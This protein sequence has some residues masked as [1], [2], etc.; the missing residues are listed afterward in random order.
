MIEA[1]F[2]NVV[3]Q[4]RRQ[5]ADSVSFVKNDLDYF[6]QYKIDILARACT[7]AG[8]NPSNILDF[9][10]GIGNS[11]PPLRSA[12]PDA[13]INCLDVSA[14]S[15]K[16]CAQQEVSN[17]SVHIYDG[18]S[19]PFVD[20]SIDLAFT[21][22]VFHHIP[23]ED[24]ILL[25][26]EIRRSLRPGGRFMLFEHNPYNPLTQWAV[27]RCPFD[28]HAILITAREMERRFRAAGFSDIDMNYHLFFPDRLSMLRPF[29]EKISWLPLGA[30]YS[31]IAA[32]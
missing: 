27:K 32:A 7:E 9:G 16:I 26:G 6:A 22:C 17:S 21:A 8:L 4:Y 19:L 3:A 1:E 15:L 31:I 28:E 18:K 11:L 5:H 30:Q 12:F 29:E 24:H 23:A 10:A 20:Q 25:L 14:E 13:A 2:D